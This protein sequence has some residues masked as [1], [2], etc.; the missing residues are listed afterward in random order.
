MI[1]MAIEE[2]IFLII[3]S[4]PFIFIKYNASNKIV[5]E[6]F[7]GFLSGINLLYSIVIFLSNF[8]HEAFLLIIIDRFSPSH[9]PLGFI[10]NSFLYNIYRIIKNK[11]KGEDN[12]YFLYIYI[13]IYI[14]LF[15]AAMIHNEILIINRC[16]FNE[17]TK[18]FLDDKVEQ[19]IKENESLID[20]E[21][22]YSYEIRFSNPDEKFYWLPVSNCFEAMGMI[23]AAKECERRFFDS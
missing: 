16:G 19:E 4:I 20:A 13:F 18:L 1:F 12:G 9:L 23:D 6:D 17:N 14:F 3:S 2:T 11:I 7:L 15:I 8:F 21:E 22:Y 5:F 10:M